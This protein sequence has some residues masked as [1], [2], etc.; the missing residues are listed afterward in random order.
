[1]KYDEKCLMNLNFLF[2]LFFLFHIFLRSHVEKGNTG[3]NFKQNSTTKVK[4][5]KHQNV[6]L[7]LHCTIYSTFTPD[8]MCVK[9]FDECFI[10]KNL[11]HISLTK[12]SKL[13]K[14]TLKLDLWFQKFFFHCL[15]FIFSFHFQHIFSLSL[16][17]LLI[18]TCFVQFF[19]T[20][21]RNNVL[22]IVRAE[23]LKILCFCIITFIFNVVTLIFWVL[24]E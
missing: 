3:I 15:C 22:E 21:S 24:A 14:K 18:Y 19:L 23:E 8:F 13:N 16:A 5:N 17:G 9:Y 10:D 11:L 20:W 1:M 7:G 6:K 4:E 2:C 12:L